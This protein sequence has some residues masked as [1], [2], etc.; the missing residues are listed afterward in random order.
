MLHSK[1]R[2]PFLKQDKTVFAL[3]ESLIEEFLFDVSQMGKKKRYKEEAPQR[4][5]TP[6][7]AKKSHFVI[8]GISKES[9]WVEDE[10]INN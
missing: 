9:F 7:Q 2:G 10:K 8:L 4:S 6:R 5:I 1:E 3:K